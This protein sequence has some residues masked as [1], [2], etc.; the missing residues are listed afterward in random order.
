MGNIMKLKIIKPKKN[1]LD[2]INKEYLTEAKCAI[3][4]LFNEINDLCH[5]HLEEEDLN[6]IIIC[7]QKCDRLKERYIETLFKNK[8]GLPFLIEDRYY[9]INTIDKKIVGRCEFVARF[10]QIFPFDIYKDLIDDI[11]NLNQKFFQI[12][13]ELIKCLE[14]V[15]N[16]FDEAYKKTFEIESM[17]REARAIK[18]SIMGILYKKKGDDLRIYL[19]SK[20]VQYIYEIINNAEEISDYLRGLIIKYPSK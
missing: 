5:G 11:I 14:L 20:L 17:R 3:E 13:E 4:L 1:P 8:R 18:F 2:E 9:I 19:T 7:E 12:G 10:L 6:K 15:E 16:N